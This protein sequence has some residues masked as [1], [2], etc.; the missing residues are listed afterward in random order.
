MQLQAARAMA[1]ELMNEHLP[2]R[3]WSFSF[4]RAKH[5]FGIAHFGKRMIF[6]SAPLVELN[7]EE[8]V[9]D[10]ILHEIAHVIA[11]AYA[12]HNWK[13]KQ[14]CRQIGAKPER[15]FNPEKV[16]TPEPKYYVTCQCGTQSHYMRRPTVNL[17][18]CR[19]NSCRK[20]GQFTIKQNY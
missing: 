2:D 1:V 4:N 3:N 16:K 15:C 8:D 5:T 17:S 19:C 13:W 18:T 20:V 12:G 10:T 11:G 14:V 6:L 9:K 7:S